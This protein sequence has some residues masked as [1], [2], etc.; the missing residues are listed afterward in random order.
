MLRFIGFSSFEV[1]IEPCLVYN[2]GPSLFPLVPVRE[3]ADWESLFSSE[4]L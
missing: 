1:L 4:I 2:F 3:P